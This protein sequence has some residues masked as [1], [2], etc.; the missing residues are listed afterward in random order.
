M[1]KLNLF[2][3]L[4]FLSGTILAQTL[5]W[6]FANPR[7]IKLSNVD[8]LQFDV[9]VKCDVDNT[10]LWAATVK[11][12]FNSATFN[13]TYTNWVVTKVG[14]FSGNNTVDGLKYTVTR[15]ITPGVG[16]L[17]VYN[18]AL[19]GDNAVKGNDPTSPLDFAVI[20]TDWAT[21]V[22]VSAR[23]LI[24]TG[25]A[26]AGI[27]F[28]E[29]GMNGF[30]LSVASPGVTGTY[31]N[32][33]IFDPR[34]FIDSYT[35][36]FYSIS[37]GWSQIGG[38]NGVQFLNWATNVSTTVWEDATISQTDNVAALAKNLTITNGSATIPVLTIPA[39]KWLTVSGTLTNPGT[40]ANL[41]VANGGSLI[42][43]SAPLA[44]VNHD[45][46][47]NKAHFLSTSVAST[48]F[49]AVFSGASTSAVWA[50]EWNPSTNA[51]V[52][53]LAGDA[54]V[55]GKGYSVSTSAPPVTAAFVGTL[56]NAEVQNTLSNL[57]FGWNLL[58][59][60]F[61][62][63]IDW[64]LVTRVGADNAVHV[65]DGTNYRAFVNGSGTL[66]FTG[67]IPAG[68]GFF[69]K[70]SVN[71]ATITVPL[72]ARVH[73]VSAFYKESSPNTLVLQANG[74][75]AIDEMI[76]TFNDN[77]TSGYDGEFDAAKLWGELYAP[78][79]Y[80]VLPNDVL[81]INALPMEGNETVNVGFKCNTTTEY[82]LTAS[83]LGS[84]D[85]STPILLEDMKTNTI[86]NLRLNPV[87]AFSYD[88]NENANRFKLHFKS[89][90][91]INDPV[92]S[93]ISI[94]SFVSDVVINNTTAQAGEVWVYDMAGRVMAHESLS[95][96][97]KTSIPL[98][99]A[100]GAYMVKVVTAKAT[101][102][103]KVFIK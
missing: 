9:Q 71:G 67:K 36:R 54:M 51:W 62:S 20:P 79:L 8:H 28:L 86:Q 68:N 74:N 27:D 39:N 66:G 15:S 23:L 85:A 69:T 16:A 83:G 94:Y 1:K 5:S 81:T 18:I 32:P 73:D 14:V 84:F 88:A 58:G 12:N 53:K 42:Q 44:T 77:A 75:N 95:S 46:A 65:W 72:A 41:V 21:M 6:R 50:K 37:K 40:A 64:A 99:V 29:E 17:K 56:N 26:M 10:Y 59:N 70:T 38:V 30:E 61:Q 11:L 24:T 60:P 78:Q 80:S 55:V 48:T 52:Y 63:A 97:A 57:N 22:T 100:V 93:G 90:T 89:T 47:N 2:L 102:N 19:T 92:N 103:Q 91:G 76:V 35:G 96:Q 4:L 45:I 43:N 34:N 7:I 3:F 13:N 87:Y 25:D 98:Q 49:G 82:S 31:T 101:V 33:N